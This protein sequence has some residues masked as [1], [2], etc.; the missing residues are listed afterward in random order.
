LKIYTCGSFISE[1]AQ[2]ANNFFQKNINSNHLEKGVTY[3]F[4]IIY[5]ENRIVVP[6]L[7]DSLC[8]LSA[9][10]MRGIEFTQN[11]LEKIAKMTNFQ[12]PKI[13]NFDSLDKALK[14]TEVMNYTQEGYVIRFKNGVRIKMKGNEYCRIH[15]LISRITPK[16]IW[17]IMLNKDDLEQIRKELP[18]E[19]ETDFTQIVNIFEKKLSEVLLDIKNVYNETKHLTD[20]ELGFEFQ[21]KESIYFQSLLFEDS[22]SLL[23][24]YRKGKFQKDL[25][26]ENSQVRKRIFKIFKPY[27]NQLDGYTPSNSVTRFSH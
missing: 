10:D 6:Y 14:T 22:K 17:E 23:F 13:Y 1:Q 9:Y 20:K 8:L 11:K 18:E 21:K 16:A 25:E 26:D 24:S 12:R 19:M 7:E 15:R 4:E 5:K 2:W 27:R 3:L